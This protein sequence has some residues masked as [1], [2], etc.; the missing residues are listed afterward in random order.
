M[1]KQELIA[2]SFDE[3]AKMGEAVVLGV[4]AEEHEGKLYTDV[5]KTTRLRNGIKILCAAYHDLMMSG[6]ISDEEKQKMLYKPADGVSVEEIRSS[7]LEQADE[8]IEAAARTEE[9]FNKLGVTNGQETGNSNERPQAG[10]A[11]N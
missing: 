4:F 11:E 9:L 1:P 10:G 8:L 3:W 5:R 6:D 7:A 2:R